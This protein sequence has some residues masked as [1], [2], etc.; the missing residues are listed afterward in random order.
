MPL[1][2]SYHT[3]ATSSVRKLLNGT[4]VPETDKA[5]DLTIH[6]KAP[7]KWLLIDLETGQEYIGSE[8]PNLYGKW[9]RVKDRPEFN[10]DELW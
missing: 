3:K 10:P 4:E 5:V 9:K 1:L 6:T 2:F 7:S 8:E